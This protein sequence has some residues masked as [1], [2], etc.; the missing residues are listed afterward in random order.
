MNKIKRK[1]PLWI[2]IVSALVTLILNPTVLTAFAHGFVSLA[3]VEF[4]GGFS[5]CFAVL[6][7]VYWV[8]AKT[9]P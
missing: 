3:I 9:K 1:L 2:P 5:F 6:Y 8:I 4:L 7:M